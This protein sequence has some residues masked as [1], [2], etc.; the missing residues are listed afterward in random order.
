M[1]KKNRFLPILVSLALA[2]GAAPVAA[3]TVEKETPKTG[4]VSSPKVSAPIKKDAGKKEAIKKDKA[5]VTAS[6]E[7]TPV[8][9]P[10]RVLAPIVEA[11]AP[12]EAPAAPVAPE[13]PAPP[14]TA[15][16][17]AGSKPAETGFFGKVRGFFKK[18]GEPSVSGEKPRAEGRMMREERPERAARASERRDMVR[19]HEAMLAEQLSEKE[20]D[21]KRF[22]A[23]KKVAKHFDMKDRIKESLRRPQMMLISR[24]MRDKGPEAEEKA[25]Q[26]FEKALPKEAAKY[27]E[28][29]VKSM[30]L[31]FA[32]G[33]TVEELKELDAF[34]GSPIGKKMRLSWDDMQRQD[35]DY[36]RMVEMIQ[37]EK[38]RA[39]MPKEPPRD[40]AKE[41]ERAE[42]RRKAMEEMIKRERA[43]EAEGRR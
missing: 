9:S 2:M 39:A 33:F 16:T 43:A 26:D 21:P 34:F 37:F 17:D 10:D 32:R 14:Q 3:Q 23:A 42:A 8:V 35:F 41:A 31:F 36:A 19:E 25:L 11:A 12:V 27:E 6:K 15:A 13:P 18:E 7:E 1:M 40:P 24:T 22:E 28:G 38:V 29:A 20:V 4:A 5:A 30:A